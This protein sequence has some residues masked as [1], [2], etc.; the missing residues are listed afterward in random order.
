MAVL[1]HGSFESGQLAF[2]NDAPFGLMDAFSELRW[3]HF[4][5]GAWVQANWVGL[6]VLPLQP[7]FTHFW[8]LA[9]G[10]VFFNKFIGPL[11]LL[12]FG[13]SAYAFGRSQRFS[14]WVSG[15]MGVAA[16]LNGDVLSHA[17]WGLGGRAVYLGLFLLAVAALGRTTSGRGTWMRVF[18]A[19]LCIGLVVVEGADTG[20]IQSVYFAAYLVFHEWV[21]STRRGKALLGSAGKLALVVVCSGWVA[22]LALSSLVGTQIQGVAGTAQDEATKQKRWEFATGW[23]YPPAEISRFA[24]PGIKGYRM[25]TPEGGNY[26][27]DVGSDGS[28]PRFSGGGEYAGVLVLLL[29]AWAVARALAGGPGQPFDARERKL[30]GFWAIASVLSLLFAFGHFAPFYR[31]L[32]GLPYFSTIRIPMKFLHPMHVGL[33]VLFGYGLE[34]LRRSYLV[35]ATPWRGG[36]L[37]RLA[38]WW[39]GAKDFDRIGR[40]GLLGIAIFGLAA[41]AWYAGDSAALTKTLARTPGIDGSEAPVIAAFSIH[42][43]WVTAGFL[44]VY[45]VVLALIASGTW[46]GREKGAFL[47]LGVVLS[48]DLFRASLPWV[49]HYDYERRYQSNVVLDALRTNA[50]EGRM[51]SRLSPRMRSGFTSPRD[52]TFPAVQNQWLEHHFQKYRI[53]TLDIIQMARVPQLDEDFLSTFEPANPVIPQVLAYGLELPNLPADQA[54]QIRSMLASAGATNFFPMRRL[55]ELTNTRYLLGGRGAVELL[56]TYFDP[57]QNRFRP[58]LE[59]S[60][61]VKSDT[62]SNRNPGLDDITAVPQPG[63][64]H[65]LIEFTGALP[66]AKLFQRWTIE[67]NTAAAL[68]RLVDPRF[69]PHS[70]LVLAD[71]LGTKPSAIDPKATA[72]IESWLPRDEVLKTHSAEPSVLL[73]VQRWHPDWKATV[74]GRPVTL[75][76]ANHLFTAVEVPAGDHTVEFHY[77]P[78]R[79]ALFVSLSALAAGAVALVFL[80]RTGLLAEEN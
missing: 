4:W 56:N 24:V 73:L 14:P 11:S 5:R 44:G 76:R 62:P 61:G 45:T 29:A 12:F 23:S 65:A 9:G 3:S 79:P 80:G 13:G 59:F 38:A 16:M 31:I 27:G 75:L 66:R 15:L 26:W 21:S 8:F 54:S 35:P 42:E 1:F 68:A 25:D 37:D 72:T 39:R 57:G 78:T 46:A 47:V 52:G 51:T 34:G 64:T 55:W 30:I 67:T 32:Y 50:W 53:Q 6:E 7:S 74:D 69:D 48:A 33:L 49:Q 18:L 36:V 40:T 22:A 20:A 41:A 60:F 28:P 17:C 10:S 77:Q 63:G 19:G 43:V 70:E 58:K 2:A 71:T